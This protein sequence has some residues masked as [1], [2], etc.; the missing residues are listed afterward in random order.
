MVA[1]RF[2]KEVQVK[3]GNQLLNEKKRGKVRNFPFPFSRGQPVN[4]TPIDW[5]GI[6]MD[7]Y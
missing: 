2:D 4:E 6:C 1:P 3:F 7:T 5:R